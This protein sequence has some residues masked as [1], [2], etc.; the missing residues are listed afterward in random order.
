MISGHLS[1][2]TRLPAPAPRQTTVAAALLL[3]LWPPPAAEAQ[4]VLGLGLGAVGSSALV[5]DSIVEAIAVRPRIAPQLALRAETPLGG[6][7]AVAAEIAVSSSDL[8]AHGD[9]T[10]ATITRLA[11]WV[12]TV[13][14]YARMTP[15]LRATAR[16]GAIVYDPG[17]SAGTL[18]AEGAPIDPVVG[19]GLLAEHR[20]GDRFHGAVTVQYDAHQFTT[21][22][23][24]SRGF[25]GETVV[26]RI[27]FGISLTRTFGRATK[28]D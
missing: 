13:G 3:A 11:V 9:T 27:A 20:F 12:P 26:H 14:L 19:V 1:T 2:D 24:Q 16:I 17:E 10:S 6:R 5:R 21:T 8:A 15:W 18:F 25:S 28:P 7:Y 23:L 22:A 4:V